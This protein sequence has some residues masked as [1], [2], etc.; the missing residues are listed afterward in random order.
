MRR[1]LAQG[2][3]A[4]LTTVAQH[5]FHVD[6]GGVDPGDRIDLVATDPQAGGSR[7]VAPDALVL[8]VPPARPEQTS[9][10]PGALVVVAVPPLAVEPVSE[11]AARWYLSYAFSR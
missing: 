7:V 3:A 9:A 11:A 8:A 5:L 2:R 10:M 6:A 1:H 4:D